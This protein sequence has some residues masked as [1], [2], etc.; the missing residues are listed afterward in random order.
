M[1]RTN[2]EKDAEIF[3]LGEDNSHSDT[4]TERKLIERV[5]LHD[6][7]YRGWTSG[8]FNVPLRDSPSGSVVIFL[9]MNF[10]DF[11]M[12]SECPSQHVNHYAKIFK[13]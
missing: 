2:N 5:G 4:E 3:Y 6:L 1:S 8:D 13:G 7:Y 10:S 12:F 9:C 11:S